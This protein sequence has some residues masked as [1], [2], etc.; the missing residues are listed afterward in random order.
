MI[1][2]HCGAD[3][4]LTM[5]D[6]GTCPPS[7]SY[8]LPEELPAPEKWYPLRVMVCTECWLVQTADFVDREECF[9]SRYAYFSSC[10][11]SWVEHAR[12]YTDSMIRRFELGLNSR[13]LEVAAND[14]YLLQHFVARDVPCYGI[15]PTESTAAVARQKGIEIVTLFFGLALARRLVHERGKVDLLAA[16]NVFAHVPNINDFAAG[17]FEMLSPSGVAT[18]EFPHVLQLI[19]QNYFDTIYHEHFSYLS[20]HAAQTILAAAGLEIFDIDELPTHGGSLRIYAHRRDGVVRPRSARVGEFLEKEVAAGL[21]N[22]A[23]YLSFPKHVEKVKDDLLTFLLQMKREGKSVAAYGAAAKGNTLLNYA[24]IRKDLL[25]FIVDRSPGKIG[26]FMP[27]SRIPIFEEEEL[28]R[29]KPERI[30]ILPWNLREEVSEQ[31]AYTR[32]W[33]AQFVVALPEL[34]IF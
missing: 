28:R 10:S 32:E 3:L 6:L 5:V 22:S 4:N 34:E 19:R 7:N 13:V 23:I 9:S 8:L 15:E 17:I 12:C 26:T 25:P 29:Q 16:N 33:G 18:I 27:G 2:R 21:L 24:G 31:L 11:T 1:C 14:G 20:L 30:V